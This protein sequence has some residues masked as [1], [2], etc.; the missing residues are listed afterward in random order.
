MWDLDPNMLQAFFI[1]AAFAEAVALTIT[2]LV[3]YKNFRTIK[4]QN[5]K[6][7]ERFQ[8]QSNIEK[9]NLTLR[10]ADWVK[11]ELSDY[12]PYAIGDGKHDYLSKT[13][14]KE[15][16]DNIA[17]NMIK[18]IKEDTVFKSL[19]L[20]EIKKMTATLETIDGHDVYVAQLR[21]LLKNKNVQ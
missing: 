13:E 17:M 2:V 1:A 5:E 3:L 11:T 9:Y 10:F 6:M 20:D 18:L 15:H 4:S 12:L 19:M 7:F 16:F 14:I 21:L 8:F